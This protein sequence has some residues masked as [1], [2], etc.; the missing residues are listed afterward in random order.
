MY[1][2]IS[3]LP[4]LLLPL[5]KQKSKVLLNLKLLAEKDDFKKARYLVKTNKADIIMEKLGISPYFFEDK[6][7]PKLILKTKNDEIKEFVANLNK[8]VLDKVKTKAFREFSQNAE[9]NMIK[10]IAPN[11]H[12]LDIIKKTIMLQL[13]ALEPVH[14]LLLGDPGT[15]KTALLKSASQLHPISSFGLGSGTSSA[16]LG[17]TVKGK[18]IINGLLPR[19]DRGLCA[20]DEL[21]LMK[22]EDYAYLYS[23]MEKGYITYDKADKHLKLQTRV[24]ILATANP[25]GDKFVG[26][27]TETLK[28]QVP[29]DTALLSRFH[30]VF[31]IRKPG[32][33][34]FIHITK[35]IIRDQTRTINKED[36]D[37]V[38]EYIAFSEKLNIEFSKKLEPEVI[39]F[40]KYVTRYEKEFIIEITPR[41]VIGFIRLAKSL[42]RLNLRNKVTKEDLEEVKEIILN[43]L[44]LR[45]K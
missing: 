35:K 13:F 22:R 45:K 30:L 28:K 14:I 5:S 40:V 24:R 38:K 17:V 16:G 36:Y 31:L 29:F 1:P 23:A 26:R 20:I 4:R 8:D 42:A 27:M 12:G 2:S 39:E 6:L 37:F 33:Q 44:F 25:K 18:E 34:G 10:L 7:Y 11:I 19:A 41:I 21:N 32:I 43:S 3:D 15:G 9:K